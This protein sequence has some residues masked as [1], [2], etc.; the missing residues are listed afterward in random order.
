MQNMKNNVKNNMQNHMLNISFNRSDMHNMHIFQYA[1]YAIL[2]VKKNVNQY[3][4]Y[5]KTCQYA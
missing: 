1:V 2:Y 5:D 3:D 4:K